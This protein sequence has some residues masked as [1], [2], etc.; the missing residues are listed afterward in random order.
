M[1]YIIKTDPTIINIKLTTKGRELLSK[2]QLTFSS[3]VLGDSEIDY[4]LIKDI[5]DTNFSESILRPVDKN[6]N[7]ISYIPQVSGG[8][9]Y[10]AIST[11]QSIPVVVRN[12]VD[13]IGFFM[14][15]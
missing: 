10:N 7:I 2:G 4:N 15:Y 12:T 9:A 13:D 11:V 5:N 1:S 3:F 6:P 8:T 14:A